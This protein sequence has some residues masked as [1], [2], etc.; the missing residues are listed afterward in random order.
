MFTG[1]STAAASSVAAALVLALA[2]AATAA[3]P[4]DSWGMDLSGGTVADANGTQSMTF[5]GQ[6][7]RSVSGRVG[8]AVRFT[9]APSLGTVAGSRYDNPGTGNFAMGVVFTSDPIPD[10]TSYSGNLMQK[11]LFGDAGQ[12]KLQLVSAARGTVDCRIGGTSGARLVTSSVNVDDGDWHTAV[13]W[14][15]GN[16][17][18][19]TV[20]GIASSLAWSPG[21]VSNTKN[22]TLGNKTATAGASDQHFGRTDYATWVVDPD[23]RWLA[24]QRVAASG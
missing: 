4:D 1:R 16:V 14:R 3:T 20:D 10:T 6:G 22:L 5:T 12:V 19:I 23:A 17:V 9:Q 11:G 21:S 2:P 7:I 13:C 24:E 15:S 8:G 18:G